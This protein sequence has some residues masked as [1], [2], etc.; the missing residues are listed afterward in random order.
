MEKIGESSLFS[1]KYFHILL[2]V[3]YESTFIIQLS[4]VVRG[5]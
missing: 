2:P 5:K 4:R 1:L 3:V